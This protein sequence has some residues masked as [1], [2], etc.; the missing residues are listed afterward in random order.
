[1]GQDMAQAAAE[2]G[3]V[4]LGWPLAQDWDPAD[5]VDNVHFSARGAEKF[6]ERLAKDVAGLCR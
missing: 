2:S 3:A 6:A 5:F 4:Y 1:L